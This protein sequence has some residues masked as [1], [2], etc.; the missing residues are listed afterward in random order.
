MYRP[1]VSCIYLCWWAFYLCF[2]YTWCVPFLWHCF[3]FI[4]WVSLRVAWFAPSAFC[5]WFGLRWFT[6]RTI[7]C[8]RSDCSGGFCSIYCTLLNCLS[9]GFMALSCTFCGLCGRVFYLCIIMLVGVLYSLLL[10]YNIISLY[11]CFICQYVYMAGFGRSLSL[12]VVYL[13]MVS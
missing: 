9:T 4:S 6:C 2:L 12:G 13:L 3:G 7:Y 11:F 8:T 1:S 10:Y 5:L